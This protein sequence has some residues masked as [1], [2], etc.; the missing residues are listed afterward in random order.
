MSRT[1]PE[2]SGAMA[3]AAFAEAKGFAQQQDT[4]ARKELIRTLRSAIAAMGGAGNRPDSGG[5]VRI[6]TPRTILVPD[7]HARAQLLVDLLESRL[8]AALLPGT[9]DSEASK[10]VFELLAGGDITIVCLGDIPHSEGAEAAGAWHRAALAL[11]ANSGPEGILSP[12]LNREMGASFRALA[13]VATLAAAFGSR[14]ICLKGNHDNLSNVDE[15]GDHPFMKYALEGEMGAAWA[16]L[17]YGEELLSIAREY[18]V[19]L[20]LVAAG[21]GFCASHAAPGR[22]IRLVELARYRRSPSLVESLIWTEN[23]KSSPQIIAESLG[24]L[25]GP[26]IT[27]ANARWISGHRPVDSVYE[28]GEEGLLLKIHDAHRAQVALIDESAEGGGT[29]HMLGLR[30]SGSVAEILARV[31]ARGFPG[32]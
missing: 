32:A 19:G 3:L 15:G 30:G 24:E 12:E 11:L 27:S 6:G 29:I 20:P 4:P 14:F 8:P 13:T 26:D 17:T 2:L 7:L 25:L 22:S 16:R 5:L 23:G 1:D 21:R 10:T 18:E 9:N 28:I 31:P